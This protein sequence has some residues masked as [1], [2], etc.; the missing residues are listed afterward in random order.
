MKDG[1]HRG[2][3][4]ARQ[5]NLPQPGPREPSRRTC[6]QP[7]GPSQGSPGPPRFRSGCV[8]GL[9]GSFFA[10]FLFCTFKGIHADNLLT[11]S[12]GGHLIPTDEANT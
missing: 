2:P 12:A 1:V 3:P 6:I 10:L 9:P 7:D 11:E 4:P 5:R 8:A